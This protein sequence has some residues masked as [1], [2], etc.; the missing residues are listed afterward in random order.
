M[1]YS[2]IKRSG[3]V[4]RSDF[5]LMLLEFFVDTAFGKLFVFFRIDDEVLF[6]IANDDVANAE[7]VVLSLPEVVE[8]SLC[9]GFRI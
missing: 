7:I 6:E 3:R 1:A 2:I 4:I 9:E 5:I 8:D